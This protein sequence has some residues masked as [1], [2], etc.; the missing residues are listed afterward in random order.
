MGDSTMVYA[1]LENVDD[2][3]VVRVADVFRAEK[4]HALR[5]GVNPELAYLFDSNGQAVP[6]HL[7]AIHAQ[8]V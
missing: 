3:L 8:Y 6:R 5:I 4:N 7:Q 2:P 1:K